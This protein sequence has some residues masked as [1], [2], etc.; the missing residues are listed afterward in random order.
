MPLSLLVMDCWVLVVSRLLFVVCC[1]SGGLCC[2]LCIG[3]F[4]LGFWLVACGGV[5]GGWFWLCVFRFVAC[6]LSVRCLIVV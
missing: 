4:G 5:V 3:G 2:L 6:V 1:L